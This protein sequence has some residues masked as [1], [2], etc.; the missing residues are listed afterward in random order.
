MQQLQMLSIH[1]KYLK[2]GR[3]QKN[4]SVPYVLFLNNKD[5]MDNFLSQ[6]TTLHVS[7]S[8]IASL[9]YD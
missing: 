6:Q 3:E 8:R 4:A 1:Q 2:A 9:P 5:K 7:F